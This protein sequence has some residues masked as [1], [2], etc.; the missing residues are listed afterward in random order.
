MKHVFIAGLIPV[1]SIQILNCPDNN[2]P[3]F[4]FPSTE[5]STTILVKNNSSL[6]TVLGEFMVLIISLPKPHS[7]RPVNPDPLRTMHR[8]QFRQPSSVIRKSPSLNLGME[9]SRSR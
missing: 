8:G 3:N 4:N 9:L 1:A 6:P 2:N 5:I 7:G